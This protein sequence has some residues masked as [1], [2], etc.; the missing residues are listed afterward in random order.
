MYCFS[1]AF[2]NNFHTT[3]ENQQKCPEWNCFIKLKDHDVFSRCTVAVLYLIA[4]KLLMGGN[5]W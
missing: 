5:V 2:L 4:Y 3:L 1:Y